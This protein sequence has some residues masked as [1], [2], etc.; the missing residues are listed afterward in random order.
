NVVHPEVASPLLR[1][2]MEHARATR[3]HVIVSANPGCLLQLRAGARLYATGQEVLH[4][5]ELLDRSYQA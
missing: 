5:I 2:K 3:A 1:D 4:L